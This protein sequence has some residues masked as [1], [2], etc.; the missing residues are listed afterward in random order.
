MLFLL[1]QKTTYNVSNTINLMYGQI[2]L[3]SKDKIVFSN[4]KIII[5]VIDFFA[6][7][8]NKYRLLSVFIDTS[9]PDHIFKS[10]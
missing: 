4:I 7:T 2:Y 1:T 5:I 9:V 8:S 3:T 10:E 6:D